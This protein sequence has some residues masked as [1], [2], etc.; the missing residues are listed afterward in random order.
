MKA[1]II[2]GPRHAEWLDLID[3]A[4]SYVDLRTAQT[5]PIRGIK[6]A[7]PDQFG[8]PAELY[9]LRVAV[10]PDLMQAG[11]QAEQAQV[12]QGLNAVTLTEFMRRHG[13]R[14][15]LA[16][17]PAPEVPDTPA[18]LFGADGRAIDS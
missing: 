7:I 11:P 3:G 14:L 18:E 17:D 12:T 8:Q 5:Y 4:T 2:G 9:D 1:L 10:Y 13:T 15:P 6:W 16:S